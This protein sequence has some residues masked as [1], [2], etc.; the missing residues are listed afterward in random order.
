[1]LEA[2]KA[3]L[4]AK[5]AQL[6]RVQPTLRVAVTVA[7]I[8]LDDELHFS[9]FLAKDARDRVSAGDIP[10]VALADLMI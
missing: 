10:G 1:M 9:P 3:Q 4:R 5:L 2:S 8:G 6:R 7:K